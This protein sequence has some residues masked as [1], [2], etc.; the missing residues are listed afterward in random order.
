MTISKTLFLGVAVLSLSA[1]Q[2]TSAVPS[3]NQVLLAD[4]DRSMVA[5]TSSTQLLSSS[6]PTCSKFYTNVSAYV[7]MPTAVKTGPS[8]GG[9]LMR[10]IALASLA[11]I[12][13]GGVAAVGIENSF[14]EAALVGTA[15]QVTYNAGGK[16]YDKIVTPDTPNPQAASVAALDPM[17]E[18]QKTAAL[19]GCPAPDEAA[20]ATLALG[21]A[22]N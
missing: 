3:P 9:Q 16:V 2:T 8:F 1:C 14:L 10:T 4:I 15:S 5:Q 18:I 13:S 7:D 22:G 21:R 11:G 6:S 19:L 12:A 17:Q 20:I